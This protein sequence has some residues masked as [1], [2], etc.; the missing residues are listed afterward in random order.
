MRELTEHEIDAVSGGNVL[1]DIYTA[2]GAFFG[3]RFGGASGAAAGGVVGGGAYDAQR[4]TAVRGAAGGWGCAKLG[5][6]AYIS[7]ISSD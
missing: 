6:C 4:Y 1:R 7:S 3:G 5:D 2:V